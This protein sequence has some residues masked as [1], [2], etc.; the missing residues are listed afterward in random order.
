MSVEFNIEGQEYRFP[1]WA[2][3]S[4]QA[5][6]LQILTSIAKKNQVDTDLLKSLNSS[7]NVLV[8]QLK[9]QAK[10]TKTAGADKDKADKDLKKAVE[11]VVNA[12]DKG[13]EATNQRNKEDTQEYKT[14]ID[15]VID[16]LEADGE[17]LGG[18][19]F[20]LAGNLGKLS[21]FLGG[22]LLTGAT[23]VGHKLLEAGDTVNEL[24]ASGIGFNSMYASVG[25]STTE[26]VAGIGALGLGFDAAAQMMKD[27]S[28][29][30][31]TQGFDRFEETMKFAAD[32]S[33]E[34]GLSFQDSMERFGDALKRRQQLLNLGNLDQGRL[35]K[36]LQTTTRFQQGFATALGVGTAEMQNFVDQLL[37]QNG[38]LMSSMLRFNDTVRSDLVAGIEVFASGLAAYGGVAG[39]QIATAFTD[40]AA[41][42]SI[43][44]SDM[45][46]GMV[47]ALPNLKG[48]MDEYINAV[49]SGTLSQEQ[50]KEM[51]DGMTRQL[52]NLSDGEKERIRLLARTGDESAK[53]MANAI[54]QFEQSKDKIKDINEQLGTTFDLDMVQKG[55]NEFRKTMAQISGGFQNA[56][57]SL[58]ADPSVTTALMDGAKEILGVFGFATDD[59]S[60]MAQD[61]SG[62]VK[63]LVKKFVPVIKSVTDTLVMFAKFLKEEFEEGGI[64]GVISAMMGKVVSAGVKALLK[65]IPLFMLGL[66][67]YS[68]IK[69]AV[70]QYL[71]PNVQNFMSQLFSKG[72]DVAKTVGIKALAYAQNMFSKGADVAKDVGMKAIRYAQGMFADVASASKNILN[73]SIAYGKSLFSGAA[74]ATAGIRGTVQAYASQ[75]FSGAKSLSSKIAGYASAYGSII[76]SKSKDVASKVASMATGFMSKL[77]KAGA[78]DVVGKMTSTAGGMLGGLKDKASGLIPKGLKDKA[79]GMGSKVSSMLSGASSSADKTTSAMTKGGKS[80]GFLKSIADAVKKFGDNKVLKGAA[81]IALLGASVGLAGVGLKQFNEVDFTSLIKGTLALGGLAALAQ[82]L[83]KGS[84]AMMKGAA[85][86]AI[87]GAS[88]VPLAFGLNL[89]KDV[90][91][92]TLVVLAG[93]LTVL[94]IAGAA[95]GSF[96]PLMLSGAVGIAALGAS[97]IPFAIAMNIMNDVGI[98]TIGV[99]AAGLITLGISAAAMGSFLPLILMGAV[100]IGALGVAIIPFAL[101]AHLLGGAMESISA[102]LKTIA[103]LPILEVAGS[104]LVLGGTFTLMLPFIPGLLLTSVAL[105]LMG[106][107]L[108]PFAIGAALASNASQ[109]LAE[110][111]Q[112]LAQVNWLNLML[113]APALL[114]LAAGMMALSAG[115]LVSGLLDGFGKLFGSE[116]PFDKLATLS[117]NAKHIVDMS[118][119]MRNMSSTMGEFESAL[120]AIDANKINDKFVV[121][122]DGIYVMV[123]ALESLGMGSMAKLVLLKSM[124]VMPEAEAPAQQSIPAPMGF[125]KADSGEKPR[126][127]GKRSILANDRR[128]AE[129]EAMRD[130]LP[131]GQT[132]GTFV[133]GK[134]VTPEAPTQSNAFGTTSMPTIDGPAPTQPATATNTTDT[135]TTPTTPT[136]TSAE[137][138]MP[139]MSNTELMERLVS[140]Q[141]ENN[142]LLAK[143]VKATSDLN[144]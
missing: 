34:L 141:T 25:K 33:E 47:T 42:G 92:G 82:T 89:M 105:G 88:V 116:S 5:Q 66:F 50:A 1:D 123:K 81:A 64:S 111:M 84:T 79:Q 136:E 135:Q 60:G 143:N 2:T 77:T 100:A 4:T 37:D 65:A 46:I 36:Q 3:E 102:G 119:E 96:L 51:A 139:N 48:P 80:G 38:L 103:D 20:D 40:A 69:Q 95:I 32:T 23:F 29:V 90:G 106:V 83:G 117:Q 45:A 63:G 122:A 97:I 15:K 44:L 109:G 107:A 127:G 114:S 132:S 16:N 134:L 21:L 98:G 94:G 24:V 78:P 67:G 124:G 129:M 30:I 68:M 62:M 35:N 138:S 6:M 22:T 101:A 18:V 74:D 14:Y 121:I 91:L 54:A 12:V 11:D 113:A 93:G 133:A 71:M 41:A 19:I 28:N 76:F 73:N 118:K 137:P 108:V 43:G 75:I 17:Q 86:V 53:Q 7:N 59:M 70:T 9:D 115:G 110:Q 112:L 10:E 128:W 99:L 31:A 87:L 125:A 140:L 8:Q 13:T 85:A 144:S 61:A 131:E 26:A 39:Q 120:E 55:T 126:F 56:F 52:G 58:F 57:Y 142:R 130:K 104:L 27:K 72:A 49:Q